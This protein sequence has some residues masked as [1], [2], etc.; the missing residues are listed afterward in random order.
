M[1]EI[2]KTEPSDITKEELSRF[3]KEIVV[4]K[5]INENRLLGHLAQEDLRGMDN[6]QVVEVLKRMLRQEL[7]DTTNKTIEPLDLISG[8]T[9]IGLTDFG[10][11]I[12][13]NIDE[14]DEHKQRKFLSLTYTI[15]KHVSHFIF[16]NENR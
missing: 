16:Q 13:L 14:N 9:A 8:R 4:L 7:I 5:A 3:K 12:A 1:K 11:R 2:R 6:E 15:G 10:K